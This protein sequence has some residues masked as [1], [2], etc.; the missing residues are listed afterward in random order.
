[1]PHTRTH[2]HVPVRPIPAS[3]LASALRLAIALYIR[4]RGRLLVAARAW[5]VVASK[6]TSDLRRLRGAEE[7]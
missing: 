7:N 2:N 5:S 6:D 1:M 4:N 3:D